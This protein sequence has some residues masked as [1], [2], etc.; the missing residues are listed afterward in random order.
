MPSIDD[1]PAVATMALA[2]AT[3]I[4][5]PVRYVLSFRRKPRDS[6]A[7]V[8]R[9]IGFVVLAAILSAAGLVSALLTAAFSERGNW[10]WWSLGI[11]AA[12]WLV[13]AALLLISDHLGRR[14]R[15][16]QTGRS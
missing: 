15:R 5:P 6:L 2:I 3:W 7:A 14:R 8:G 4:V 12:Y 9:V 11:I 1:I 13:F 10:A 16:R